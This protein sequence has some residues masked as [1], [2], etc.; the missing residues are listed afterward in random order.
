M[1]W[2]GAGPV[3]GGESAWLSFDNTVKIGT[4]FH[5]VYKPRWRRSLLRPLTRLIAMSGKSVPRIGLLLLMLGM[6]GSPVQA[7]D[8]APPPARKVALGSESKP[9]ATLAR[10]IK[11][12]TGI[13]VDVS[14]LDQTKAIAADFINVDFW[15]AIERLAERSDSRVTTVGGKVA[16]KPGKSAA[17]ACVSGPFRFAV[18]E[19][20][21]RGDLETGSTTYDVTMDVCWEPWLL[22]FRIDTSPH[23]CAA[24]DDAGLDLLVRRGGART[25]TSGNVATLA[26]RPV[27]LDRSARSF[28]VTGSIMVTIADELL[29][30]A[31]D[32]NKPLPVAAQKGVSATVS[33]S[34][35]DGSDWFAEVEMRYPKGNVNWESHEFYWARNNE[36]RLLNPKGEPIKADRVDFGD[37]SIRYLFKNRA[38]QIGP[39]WKLEYRTPGPMREI[40][41]P[42]ELKD[43]RLP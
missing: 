38:K 32:A 41:V 42:F 36:L 21:V 22:A 40:A 16:L 1:A 28:S 3:I 2:E 43:I 39:G 13:D 20:I 17:P 4:A 10:E 25:F 18:R 23:K 29:T 6:L 24:K 31:F 34:G 33:R 8:L 30:F 15:T 37:G 5:P 26:I 27:G 9:L 35:A 19:V 11:E 7:A 12:Q 14:T